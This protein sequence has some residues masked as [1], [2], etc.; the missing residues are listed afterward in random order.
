M[1]VHDTP[2]VNFDKSQ[3]WPLKKK[4]K[5]QDWFNNS[6]NW[7][8]HHMLQLN[9]HNQGILLVMFCVKATLAWT[10]KNK[11]TKCKG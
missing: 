4:K 6:P 10:Q 7:S 3:S 2:A 8:L 1:V 5:L 11:T 9:K